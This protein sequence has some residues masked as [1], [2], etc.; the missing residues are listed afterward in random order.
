MITHRCVDLKLFKIGV[1]DLW[2]DSSFSFIGYP[3]SDKTE[4]IKTLLQHHKRH[5]YFYNI[6]KHVIIPTICTG[7]IDYTPVLSTE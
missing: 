6:S 1:K 5:I 3:A 2:F 4:H 7:D